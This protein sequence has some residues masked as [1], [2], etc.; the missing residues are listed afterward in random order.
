[1]LFDEDGQADSLEKKNEI[2]KD[3]TNPSKN[4]LTLILKISLLI[5][6]CLP[7]QQD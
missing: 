5:Q 1:M 7:L 3:L 6:M 4:K 2:S